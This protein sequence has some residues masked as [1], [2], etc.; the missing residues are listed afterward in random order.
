MVSHLVNH[1]VGSEL[2]YSIYIKDISFQGHL[3]TKFIPMIYVPSVYSK[4]I[5]FAPV[6][7]QGYVGPVF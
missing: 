7:L 6:L 3:H 1:K 4:D 5:N 2:T